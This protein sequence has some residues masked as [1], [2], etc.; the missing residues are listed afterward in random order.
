MVK[1]LKHAQAFEASDT[2]S[3][4]SCRCCCGHGKAGHAAQGPRLARAMVDPKQ[5]SWVPYGATN[6]PEKLGANRNWRWSI[7]L[8]QSQDGTKKRILQNEVSQTD[9]CGIYELANHLKHASQ[10]QG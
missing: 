5:P 6:D 10:W 8:S 4:C 3:R 1:F 9:K 2:R 7:H